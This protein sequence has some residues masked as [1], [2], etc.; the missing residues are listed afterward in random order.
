MCGYLLSLLLYLLYVN[1]ESQSIWR[2]IYI[3]DF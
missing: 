2:Y 1:I 3:L